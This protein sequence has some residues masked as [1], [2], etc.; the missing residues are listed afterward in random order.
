MSGKI[1]FKKRDKYLYS[2]S[3]KVP[4]ILEVPELNYLSVNGEGNPNSDAFQLAIKALYSL[5]YK[6]KMGLKKENSIYGYYDYVVPPLEGIW[7]LIDNKKSEPFDKN[8][9]K[10]NIMIRQPEFVTNDILESWRRFLLKTE[11]NPFL[12][13]A[14]LTGIEDGL[15]CQIL[16][17]G[18]FD[19]EPETFNK[20]EEWCK[21][22]GY[23]RLN[24][25]HREI[26][27]S[28]FLKTAEEKLKTILRFKVKKNTRA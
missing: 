12:K 5:S 22:N 2:P 7:D 26:Y 11:N 19:N 14:A 3:A 25:T 13:K 20:M 16:H 1:D 17:I 21:Y 24:K 10:W 9:L 28:N 15:C 8:N 23:E 27:L 4:G 18:S 6:I